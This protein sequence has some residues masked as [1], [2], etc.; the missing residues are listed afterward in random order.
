MSITPGKA[1]ALGTLTA[2]LIWLLAVQAAAAALVL[3]QKDSG[4]TV[5]VAV[6]QGLKVDLNL[7]G[8]N[9]VV[10]PEFDPVVLT[11]VG[12]SMQSVIGPQGSSA[13]IVF[14][15]VVRQ[16]GQT[17]LVITAKGAGGQEGKPEPLLKVKIV[18]TGG[19][20]AV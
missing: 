4:R 15:F 2:V 7:G 12:Q 5:T 1:L 3:T 13:R 19:G 6:G 18:A 20:Q 10:A 11:L 17:H 8:G 16:A 14:D 9:N